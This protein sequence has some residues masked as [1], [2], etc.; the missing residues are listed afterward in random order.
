[1]HWKLAFQQAISHIYYWAIFI[2]AVYAIF[3]YKTVDKSTRYICMLIWLGILTET[4]AYFSVIKFKTNLP[5]YSISSI[6][7]FAIISFYFSRSIAYLRK[8]NI[9][10][11]AALTGLLAGILNILF[12]QPLYTLNS[13]FVFFESIVVVCFSLYA[14]Y[15]MLALPD[16]RLWPETHFWLSCILLLYVCASLWGWAGYDYIAVNNAETS[17]LL[18]ICMLAIN[19][20][21]Y[22]SYGII[23][24]LYPHMRQT[25]V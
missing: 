7:E 10:A 21:T 16:L 9:G 23:L 18:S 5:V 1:M 22:A 4:I 19:V 17:I 12:F 14:I 13:N 20:I 6:L 15:K 2:T 25:H 24:F 8:R 3:R 11:I